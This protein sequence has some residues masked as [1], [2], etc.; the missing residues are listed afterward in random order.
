MPL[1]L[2]ALYQ[3]FAKHKESSWVLK[4]ENAKSLYEFVKTHNVKNVLD[5]GTGMGMSAA[6]VALALEEKKIEYKINTVE[7]YEKCY[8]L[9]QTEIPEELRKNITFHRTD[10]ILWNHP[11]IP[12]Q[13]FS[14]FKE[15]PEGEFD[16]IIVDGPGP[17]LDENGRLI[18]T[19]NGDVLKFHLENNIKPGT[20]IFFDGRLKALAM[21]ERFY[22]ADFW[23]VSGSGNRTHFLERCEGEPKFKDERK[24]MYQKD[25]YFT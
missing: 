9:A 12:D 22:P 24:A 21:L 6:V 19:P 10:S 15:L 16:L 17:W 4:P 5:L 11:E 14:N 8:K 1:S 20:F 23:L 18:E 7:Q 3:S 2:N 13:L 25:G